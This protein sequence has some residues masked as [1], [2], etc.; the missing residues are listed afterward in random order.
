MAIPDNEPTIRLVGRRIEAGEDGDLPKFR[1]C[2]MVRSFRRG[3]KLSISY[4]GPYTTHGYKY[5][6]YSS[7]VALICRTHCG[8]ELAP[9]ISIS[10]LEGSVSHCRQVKIFSQT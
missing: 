3:T 4:V 8:G 10:N 1:A 7:A 5:L 9:T 2:G 6:T